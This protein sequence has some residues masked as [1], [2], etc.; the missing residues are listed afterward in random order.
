MI[1]EINTGTALALEVLVKINV[2]SVT[3][4]V[5]FD[6]GYHIFYISSILAHVFCCFY[7]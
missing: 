5:N 2:G 6:S 7:T 1:I 3:G 4:S